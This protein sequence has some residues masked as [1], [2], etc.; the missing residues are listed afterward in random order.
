MIG[1]SL[2]AAMYTSMTAPTAP[3]II[4]KSGSCG[5]TTFGMCSMSRACLWKLGLPIPSTEY[6]ATNSLTRS[7]S[8]PRSMK[9]AIRGGPH[10]L[11]RT[12]F[13]TSVHSGKT[14]TRINVVMKAQ[15]YGPVIS[16]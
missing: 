16:R 8:V 5:I 10:V 1:K 7:S 9:T 14:N 13:H 15:R 11:R 2:L 6:A 3:A 4:R 12:G